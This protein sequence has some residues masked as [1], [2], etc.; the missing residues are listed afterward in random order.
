MKYFLLFIIPFL[1]YS[2][3]RNFREKP[4]YLDYKIANDKLPRQS[5]IRFA[6]AGVSISSFCV[7]KKNSEY[8]S[9]ECK[10]WSAYS[11]IDSG[12]LIPLIRE[13]GF[14]SEGDP[15]QF[16][17]SLICKE[18][19]GIV[20]SEIDE[21]NPNGR[22]REEELFCGFKDGSLAPYTGLINYI[23]RNAPSIRKEILTEKEKRK[24]KKL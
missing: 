3:T 18:V 22:R 5:I 13:K 19:K 8:T 20:E 1:I 6:K 21:Y 10:A 14:F 7:H 15:P 23:Y 2:E 16:V 24:K 17:A 12:K 9:R 4:S 11:Y